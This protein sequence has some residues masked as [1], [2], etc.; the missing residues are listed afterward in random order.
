MGVCSE[1]NGVFKFLQ[2]LR[3]ESIDRTP[4]IENIIENAGKKLEVFMV[5]I[6]RKHVKE[7]AIYDVFKWVRD[8]EPNA[9]VIAF[10][11]FKM[12]VEPQRYRESTIQY[13]GKDGMSL[14]GAAVFYKPDKTTDPDYCEHMRKY[15]EEYV[16]AGGR[17]IPENDITED[18]KKLED[19]RL[20]M[21]FVDNVMENDKRQDYILTASIVDALCYR[22]KKLVP[23][24]KEIA[25]ISENERNYNNDFLPVMVPKICEIHDLLPNTFLHPDAFCGKNCV[26]RHLTVI[27]RLV[28]RYIQETENDVVTPE[29]LMDALQGKEQ[30]S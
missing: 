22:I 28:K 5:H 9:R 24:A 20:S 3:S 27:W 2:Q 6:V 15:D 30:C 16:Q 14:H 8:G 1:C 12:K 17:R 19:E 4:V 18:E 10:I 7:E 23:Q 11:D 29:D 25:L 13:Y 21:L 26:D